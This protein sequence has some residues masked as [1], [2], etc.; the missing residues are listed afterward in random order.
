MK[1]AEIEAPMGDNKDPD[2]LLVSVPEI[3]VW[4]TAFGCL[5]SIDEFAVKWNRKNI[6]R[7]QYYKAVNGCLF[8]LAETADATHRF[9]VLLPATIE[10]HYRRHLRE[11]N[12]GLLKVDFSPSFWRWYNWWNDYINT[13]STIEREYVYDLAM[14][15]LPALEMYRPGGDWLHYRS[16]PVLI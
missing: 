2:P 8:N 5:R 11:R 4:M 14:E 15:R 1:N 16:N 6:T 3:S 7:Q 12:D 13:L 9:G 10:P